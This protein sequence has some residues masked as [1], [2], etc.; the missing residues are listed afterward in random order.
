MPLVYPDRGGTQTIQDLGDIP[1]RWRIL[2]PSIRERI[3]RAFELYL[4]GEY[5]ECVHVLTP[6]L[7][8]GLREV[9]ASAGV[10]VTTP[11]R[12][13]EPGGSSPWERYSMV[14]RGDSMRAGGST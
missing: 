8:A 10:P 13:E 3:A 11:P 2:A 6:R 12:G 7:E 5:D 14:W 4:D 9:A 1:E